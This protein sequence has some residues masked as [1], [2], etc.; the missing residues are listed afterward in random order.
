MKL[1]HLTV[2]SILCAPSIFLVCFSALAQ[3]LPSIQQ[4]SLYAPS[5]IHIDGTDEKW[6][7]QFQAYNNATNVFYTIANDDSKLY[8]ILQANDAAVI[9]KIIYGSIT[10][11][12][13]GPGKDDRDSPVRITFPF[14]NKKDQGSLLT[15]KSNIVAGAVNLAVNH[16]NDSLIVVLNKQ[17]LEKSFI[18]VAGI[19]SIPDSL[20]AVT[21]QN[22]IAAMSLFGK[23]G[24]YTCELAIPLKYLEGR[25][26][27]DGRFRYN[28]KLNGRFYNSNTSVQLSPDGQYSLRSTPGYQPIAVKTSAES[29]IL[30]FS[31]DFWGAYTLTRK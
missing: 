25:A 5:A 20:I 8:L 6:N 21:S 7:N 9:K 16:A 26:I 18:K 24:T 3:K 31:T 11:M 2:R 22:S 30:D 23:D 17:I 28:I 15:K 14:I 4:N 27:K 12:V 1:N 29:L 13:T 10:F 19:P